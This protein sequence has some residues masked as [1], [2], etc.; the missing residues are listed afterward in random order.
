M[1]DTTP[2]PRP[3]TTGSDTPRRRFFRWTTVAGIVAAVATGLGVTAF[4]YGPGRW[5]CAGFLG[6]PLDPAKLDERLE[7]R[8][9]HLYAEIGATDAQRQQLAP[10]VKA[11]A[12]DLLTLRTRMHAV[13]HQAVELLSQDPVDRAALEALRAN[14]FQLVEQASRRVAEALGDAAEVLTPAQRE[15]LAERVERW[16]E[17]RG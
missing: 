7:R 4:A 13:G 6:A 15:R 11:A 5:H 17:P 16:H 1:N 14:H 8:L 12:Q 9:Q 2:T 3:S 10:I